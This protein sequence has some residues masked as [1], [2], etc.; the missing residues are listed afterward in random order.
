MYSAKL[1]NSQTLG[2]KWPLL[3]MKQVSKEDE[4][5]TWK[6]ADQFVADR[7]YKNEESNRYKLGMR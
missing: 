4:E 3:A 6:P 1:K 7:S 5:E 2:I